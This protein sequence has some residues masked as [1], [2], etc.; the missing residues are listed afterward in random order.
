MGMTIQL[1]HTGI[2]L[3]LQSINSN[4]FG[5]FQHEEKDYMINAVTI[6]LLKRVLLNDKSEDNRLS[7]LVS[8][9]DI[10]SYYNTLQ[11]YIKEIETESVEKLG[12]GYRYGKLPTSIPTLTELSSGLLYAGARY[13][14][15]TVGTADL[16]TFGYKV[17]PVIN[18]EFTCEIDNQTGASI[19]IVAGQ[20]YR[21]L[22]SGGS[23]FITYGA[24]DN[25]PGTVFTALTGGLMGD[26][27]ASTALGLLSKA[28]T[29]SSTK[30]LPVGDIGFLL[31]ISSS[32]VSKYG[33]PIMS[34]T[35]TVGEKYIVTTVGTTNLSS[36]GG[37]AVNDLNCIF[38][39]TSNG[40]IT[41][42]GGTVLYKVKA[43]TTSLVKTNEIKLRLDNK[44]GT[45]QSSPISA[46][47]D[48]RI[49]VYHDNKF[50]INSIF[51]NYIKK[52]IPVNW[53]TNVN[54]DLPDSIQDLIV[55]L[56]AKLMAGVNG[57]PN[58]PQLVNELKDKE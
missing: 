41:W 58:Y 28:P 32:S 25:K 35:L 30:L 2:D 26:G 38:T 24:K 3:Y 37:Y 31:P 44:F 1:M 54:S 16:S 19:T 4:M 9:S 50:D 52:P 7:N 45:V 33:N 40:I 14:V 48:N 46:F 20:T 6:D 57:N 18:E 11:V 47:A 17:Q 5:N 13:K 10:E 55:Q 34:G 22:N 23:N 15:T 29:W 36:V 8:Y 53:N 12:F 42:A 56:T 39:C 43:Y 27:T 49:E 21:I 51:I